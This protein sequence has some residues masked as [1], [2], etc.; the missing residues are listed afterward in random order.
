MVAVGSGVGVTL[1]G[2]GTDTCTVWL[3]CDGCVTSVGW[4]MAEFR[5]LMSGGL[6]GLSTTTWKVSVTLAPAG[7]LATVQ[8]TMPR[9]L[10]PPDVNAPLLAAETNVVPCG[11][12][13]TRGALVS[14][15]EPT[16]V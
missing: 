7:R 3:D 2:N 11:M 10:A 4:T 12:L 14:V 9:P 13:S 1:G 15:S 5:M 6:V 8:V 16:L